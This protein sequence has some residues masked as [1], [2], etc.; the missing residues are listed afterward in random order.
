MQY[1]AACR[2]QAHSIRSAQ[3]STYCWYG[4]CINIS[5]LA[6]IWWLSFRPQQISADNMLDKIAHASYFT[7]SLLRSASALPAHATQPV[8]PSWSSIISF[9]DEAYLFYS[10]AW[11]FTYLFHFLVASSFI[12]AQMPLPGRHGNIRALCAALHGSLLLP[13]PFHAS[14]LLRSSIGREVHG[15]CE[16]IKMPFSLRLDIYYYLIFQLHSGHNG[17][18]FGDGITSRHGQCLHS[19]I[20]YFADY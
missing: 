1:A 14:V 17:I 9:A 19:M 12:Y 11:L 5:G 3:N 7:I 13:P 4:F 16:A 18:I 10:F 2:Q 8:L 20:D 15:R 6:K